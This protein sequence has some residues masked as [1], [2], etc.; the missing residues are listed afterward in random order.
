MQGLHA[1]SILIWPY[2]RIRRTYAVIPHEEWHDVLVEF[3]GTTGE[4]VVVKQRLNGASDS[5]SIEADTSVVIGAGDTT[6][7]YVGFGVGE[8]A[9]FRFD[10]AGTDVPV[11]ASVALRY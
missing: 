1:G 11:A 10:D 4:H 9:E 6:E 3:S 2:G 8:K 7:R 5:Q